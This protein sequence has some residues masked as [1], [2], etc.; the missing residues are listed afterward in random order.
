MSIFKDSRGDEWRVS[1]D[2]FLLDDIRKQTGVD[3]ADLTS[4]GWHQIETDAGA[5]VRVLAVVC[6]DEIKARG[7]QSRD[8]ARAVRQE[9]IDAGRAALWSEGADFFPQSQ[10]SAIASN[11]ETR[12]TNQKHAAL[13]ATN[14]ELLGTLAA[15]NIDLQTI[16]AEMIREGGAGTTSPT[17]PTQGEYA[18]GLTST[19]LPPPIALVVNAESLPTG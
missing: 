16:V 2:A 5:C 18:G 11:C 8:F 12:R 6:A 15:A 1:L 3:L 4:G 14:R 13:L 19:P 7:R 17:G 10:W 9:A